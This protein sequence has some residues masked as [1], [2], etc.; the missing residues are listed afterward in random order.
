M[1]IGKRCNVDGTFV[2]ERGMGRVSIGDGTSIGSGCL[3]MCAG[4]HGIHI[5]KNTLIS[6]DVTIMD[7]NAHSTDRLLRENDAT[8]WLDGEMVGRLGSFKNWYE[9]AVAPVTIG[10]GV[11]VGFGTTIMKGVTIGDGAVIASK[12]VITKDVAPYSVVGGNPARVL[13][14]GA[15][16][17]AVERERRSSRFP[18]LPLPEVSFAR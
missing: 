6:W 13:R 17:E 11:W 4:S 2:F 3:F 15:E 8:D 18:N 16:L 10:D 9:V 5:G 7:T 14:N 1:R 12:S